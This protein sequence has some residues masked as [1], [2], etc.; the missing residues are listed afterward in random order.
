M[1][2]RES[3]ASSISQDEINSLISKLQNLLP[4]E[5]DQRALT[6][7]S[8][9]EALKE[10]CRYIKWLQRE[11]DDLSATISQLV[12][13]SDSIGVDADILRRLLQQ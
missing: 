11:V 4:A 2:S 8:A 3:R 1:S 10:I 12:A 5:S 9:S 7:A 6:T 13:S